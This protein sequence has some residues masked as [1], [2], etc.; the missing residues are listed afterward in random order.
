[1]L[2]G[3]GCQKGN[4]LTLGKQGKRWGRFGGG[5]GDG[6]IRAEGE[7]EIHKQTNNCQWG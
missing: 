2:A 5:E 1:L 3:G 4:V 6:A 7:G